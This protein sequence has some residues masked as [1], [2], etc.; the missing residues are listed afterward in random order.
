MLSCA[1]KSVPAAI[2]FWFNPETMNVK[3]LPLRLAL[4]LLPAEVAIAPAVTAPVLKLAGKV[5][6]NWMP[7]TGEVLGSK[8]IGRLTAVPAEPDTVPAAKVGD[9]PPEDAGETV[10]ARVFVPV[11]PALVALSVTLD[12]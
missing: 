6:L 1:V 5:R 9:A 8:V 4:T 7:A 3:M 12:V 2:V 11:P 10:K